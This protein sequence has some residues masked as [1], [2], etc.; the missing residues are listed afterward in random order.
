MDRTERFYK[1]H[2]LLTRRK[3]VPRD[4][5]LEELSVSR[6]TFKRDLEYLR[7][8]MNMPVVWDRE[9]GGYRLDEDA[10][11]A[12]IFQLPGLWFSPE[13]IHALL[14]MEQLLERLQ[15]GLLGPQV[16]PLR[17]RIRRILDSGDFAAGEVSRRI[18]ILQ[19]GVRPVEPD[20]FQAIASALLSR[21]R[22]R[23]EHYQRARNESLERDVSPQRLV[24]YRD[25]WYL[26][27]W[28]H[29]RRALRTFSVDA[30]ASAVVLSKR[31]REIKDSTLDEHLGSGFGIFSGRRTHTAVLRFSPLRARW[32]SRETWHSEQDGNFELDGS[33]VLSVP[34][35][36]AR[37][38]VMDILKYGPDVE[39]LAPAQLREMV[40][41]QLAEASALYP[42]RSN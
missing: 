6:A 29:L 33:Y 35:S 7:D 10:S 42:E 2:G 19:I 22:L 31:A 38:L 30:I 4:V 16:R 12:H 20:N 14:T 27:A 37:E 23:I 21:H 13:E 18:R 17:N 5:F 24:Y 26:D 3:V 9:R 34:Y 39:V 28:C 36:D 15:P 8:R 1:I 11:S 41:E 40:R 32:V 25:N